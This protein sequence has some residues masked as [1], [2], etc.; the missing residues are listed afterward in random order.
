MAEKTDP[1]P[2]LHDKIVVGFDGSDSSMAA[3]RWAAEEA[4]LRNAAVTVISSFATSPA[5]DYGWGMGYGGVAMANAA[6]ELAEWT[7]SELAKGVHE[8]FGDYPTV[9]HDYHAVATRPGLALLSAAEGADIVVVGRSGAGALERAVLGSVTTDLLARSSC[10]VAVIPAAPTTT[11]GAV[12]V[13]T[14]GSEHSAMAVRWA[15]DE[16]DRRANRLTVAHSWKASHRLTSD[17][18]DGSDDLHKVDAELVLDAAVEAARE[19]SGG[20]IDRRLIEGGAVDSMVDLSRAADMIVLGSR[21]RG[22]FTS[23]LL[24]SVA[25]AVASHAACPT[26]IVR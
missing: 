20:D 19:R 6:E 21:G 1:T 15:V 10:P 4:T 9:G 14:D 16:A 8:V 23:M 26:V 17:R 3:L 24:G 25:H 22:G 11:G 12:L 18:L 7:R 13:G 5:L 2:T